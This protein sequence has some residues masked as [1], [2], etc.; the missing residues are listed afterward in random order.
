MQVFPKVLSPT[1][2]HPLR[3]KMPCG[4]ACTICFACD[5]LATSSCIGDNNRRKGSTKMWMHFSTPMVDF[6]LPFRAVLR[7]VWY[8]KKEGTKHAAATLQWAN[9]AQRHTQQCQCSSGHG[10]SVDWSSHLHPTR[11][12]RWMVC[13]K[14]WSE[15]RELWLRFEGFRPNDPISSMD[16]NRC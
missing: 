6:M 10:A 11:C 1:S 9:R 16:G 15:N 3:R 7:Y 2:Y 13:E 8:A 4:C 5:T 12:R 14:K